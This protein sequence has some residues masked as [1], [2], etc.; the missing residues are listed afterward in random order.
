VT[1]ALA[2]AGFRLLRDRTGLVHF[3]VPLVL[4]HQG[5]GVLIAGQVFDQYPDQLALEHVAKEVGL[6]PRSIWQVARL[7]HPV[8]PASLR[9][10]ADL[11]ATLAH[12]TLRSRYHTLTEEAR[13]NELTQLSKQLRQ[14]SHE[15]AEANHRKDEF[16]AMLAHELRNPLAPMCSA[17]QIIR[18]L[19][20]EDA[21]LRWA[22]EVVDHQVQY[23]SRLVDD[24]LDVSRFSNGM[25]RLQTK[26]TDLAA[27]VARALETARPAI[28][29]CG[30]QLSVTLP[31]ERLLVEGDPIRLAQV[32]ANL[33]NNATK[34]HS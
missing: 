23:M 33:L 26:V 9:I 4:D 17:V 29:A 34:F 14:R 8:K 6:P 18:R 15:L 7:E 30:Q 19:A 32:L 3:A 5:L 21:N 24:L 20:R 22:T 16:L 27:V 25:M 28:E 13:L 12:N 2:E 11:L 10:Y 1:E 31:P